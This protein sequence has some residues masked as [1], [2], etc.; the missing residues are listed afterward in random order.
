MLRSRF[1]SSP[2]PAANFSRLV[3]GSS[4]KIAVARKSPLE[5]AASQ[6]CP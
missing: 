4:R 6:T 1:V 3:P 2:K 5:N